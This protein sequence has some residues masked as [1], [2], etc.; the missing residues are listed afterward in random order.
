MSALIDLRRYGPRI[1]V[2]VVAL[3]AIIADISSFFR[4]LGY[5]KDLPADVMIARFV[6]MFIS[7]AI[8]GG[9]Q[10]QRI[11]ACFAST[12]IL[13]QLAFYI[14]AIDLILRF[15]LFFASVALRAFN[16]DFAAKMEGI[17]FG[18]TRED[19]LNPLSDFWLLYSGMIVV[20]ISL[21]MMLNELRKRDKEVQRKKEALL[22]LDQDMP[23]FP[24]TTGKSS[25]GSVGE[26]LRKEEAQKRLLQVRSWPRIVIGII[27]VIPMKDIVNGFAFNLIEFR[28][29]QWYDCLG[30][31]LYAV[32]TPV[33][34]YALYRKSLRATRWFFWSAV[35]FNIDDFYFTI[36]GFVEVYQ[37]RNTSIT[38][39][40]NSAS[41]TSAIPL[42]TNESTTAKEVNIVQEF[43][44]VVFEI[45]CGLF[46]LWSIW[47]V[48]KDLEARNK[49]IAK[50]QHESREAE[51][52][53]TTFNDE[54]GSAVHDEK[55]QQSTIVRI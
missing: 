32:A 55:G 30:F 11:A 3:M 39:N 8:F 21:R 5:I 34:F 47:Q 19:V 10:V 25:T 50:A 43:G 49:R 23:P 15:L 38:N 7:G 12:T 35:I 29:F 45:L 9:I 54:K 37:N 46:I 16:K 20:G 18:P 26:V 33:A 40:N 51:S 4:Q 36:K 48:I 27:S 28:T 44:I 41:T 22:R 13:V 2:G 31:T 24:V 17:S 6:P 53:A 1:V 42:P 14:W 52:S